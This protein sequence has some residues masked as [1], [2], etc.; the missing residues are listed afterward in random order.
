MR[1]RSARVL[2]LPRWRDQESS[3]RSSSSLN[4]IAASFEVR[5]LRARLPE[6]LSIALRT[7]PPAS[8]NRNWCNEFVTQAQPEQLRKAGFFQCLAHRVYAPAHVSNP[9]HIDR[10][11]SRA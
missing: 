8:L 1:A 11:R 4:S 2:P 10:Q 3:W 6:F 7:L 5:R 9:R